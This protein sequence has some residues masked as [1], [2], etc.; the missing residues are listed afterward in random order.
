MPANKKIDLIGLCS[1][2]ASL[3]VASLL[4]AAIEFKIIQ[5]ESML[6]AISSYLACIGLIVFIA[7]GLYLWAHYFSH[8]R[9]RA[10][11][12]VMLLYIGSHAIAGYIAHRKLRE[13]VHAQHTI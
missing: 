3:V 7:C 12:L 2:I 11:I 10:N 9:K 4:A 13:Q 8:V 6:L 5:E 1:I